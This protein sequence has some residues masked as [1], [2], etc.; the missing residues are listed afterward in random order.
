MILSLHNLKLKK[1]LINNVKNIIFQILKKLS[2]V[3]FF[4]T[5]EEFYKSGLLEKRID[6]RMREKIIDTFEFDI[7]NSIR[8]YNIK[9]IQIDSLKLALDNAKNFK[10]KEE[11]YYLS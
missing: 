9:S 8:S 1:F 4:L 5:P 2:K 11:F 3:I 7:L 6:D 10:D